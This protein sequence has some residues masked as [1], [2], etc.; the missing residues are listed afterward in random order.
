[1]ISKLK[2]IAIETIQ[3]QIRREEEKNYKMERAPVRNYTN[4]SEQI[5]ESPKEK[6]GRKGAEKKYLK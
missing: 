3:K 1:M 2:V 5:S 6:R 4:S